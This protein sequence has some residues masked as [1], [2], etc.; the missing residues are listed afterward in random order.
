MNGKMNVGDKVSVID[1][2]Y[3]FGTGEI[4]EKEKNGGQFEYLV[5][6]DTGMIVSF[7]ESELSKSG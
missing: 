1:Y 6:F 5:R 2:A 4:I 7:W 3:S